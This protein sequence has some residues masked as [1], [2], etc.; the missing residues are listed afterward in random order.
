MLPV[1]G[2]CGDPGAEET[3]RPLHHPSNSS[4]NNIALPLPQQCRLSNRKE[5]NPLSETEETKFTAGNQNPDL[6][7]KAQHRPRGGR[8]VF[9]YRG[10]ATRCFQRTAPARRARSDASAMPRARGHSRSSPPARGALTAKQSAPLH[11]HRGTGTEQPEAH[12]RSKKSGVGKKHR[13][14]VKKQ[15]SAS[16]ALPAQRN[17]TG[18]SHFPRSYIYKI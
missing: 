8:A 1:P 6:G 7:P 17:N 15:V 5:R 14:R 18:L 2:G 10:A 4:F 16:G 13:D 11:R 3:C 9:A 12:L